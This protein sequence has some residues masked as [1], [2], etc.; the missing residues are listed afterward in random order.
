MSLLLRRL[1][2]V[3][4]LVSLTALAACSADEAGVVGGRS[5]LA[6]PTPRAQPES[7][8]QPAPDDEDLS[9]CDEVVAGIEAFNRNDFDET[10]ARF[11]RAVPLA[12][13]EDAAAGTRRSSDLLEAVR[14]YAALPAEDYPEA[15]LTSPDFARYKQVTLGQCGSGQPQSPDAPDDGIQA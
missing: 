2:T 10:V 12:E 8:S 4:A 14:Y 13:A 9:A 6:D 5:T 3:V 7:P 11:E 1:P 15:S